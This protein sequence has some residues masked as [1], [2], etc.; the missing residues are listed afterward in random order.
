[1]RD[2]VAVIELGFTA[3]DTEFDSGSGTDESVPRDPFGVELEL[4]ER[5]RA[6]LGN[7]DEDSARSAKPE[8]GACNR[9]E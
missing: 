4:V 6:E 5:R 1:M 2:G 3:R 8:I 7:A 9:L